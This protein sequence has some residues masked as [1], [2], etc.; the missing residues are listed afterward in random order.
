MRHSVEQLCLTLM[1]AVIL[2][3]QEL[4]NCN[5]MPGHVNAFAVVYII[6]TSGVGIVDDV[7]SGDNYSEPLAR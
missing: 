2:M 3:M 7:P 6:Q 1:T 4:S 5:E